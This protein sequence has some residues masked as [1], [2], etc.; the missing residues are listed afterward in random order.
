[1]LNS[2]LTTQTTISRVRRQ[3]R[4]PVPD[5][6]WSVLGVRKYLLKIYTRTWSLNETFRMICTY[7]L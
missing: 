2:A 1:M 7:I 5:I 6:D 3:V 4:D